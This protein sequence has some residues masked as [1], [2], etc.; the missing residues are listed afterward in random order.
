MAELSDE[1]LSLAFH[2][3]LLCGITLNVCT[4]S[5]VL[6]RLSLTRQGQCFSLCVTQPQ[7]P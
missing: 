1:I 7:K 5:S 4:K 3:F 6:F 2:L